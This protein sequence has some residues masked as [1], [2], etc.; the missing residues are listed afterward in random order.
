MPSSSTGSLCTQCG[1]CCDGTLFGRVELLLA[2]DADGLKAQGFRIVGGTKPRFVQPCPA[3]SQDCTCR[4]YAQR[5]QQCRAFDCA[6]LLRVQSGEI[7][8]EAAERLIRRTRKQ[9]AR[10]RQLL[11][12]LGD[13]STALPLSQRFSRLRRRLETEAEGDRKGSE[14]R[15]ELFAELTLAVHELQRQLRQEFYP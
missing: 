13:R 14:E 10:V 9:S 11:E 2:D 1:L 8:V 12:A 5:P 6:L 4:I 3:L 7:R 15:W